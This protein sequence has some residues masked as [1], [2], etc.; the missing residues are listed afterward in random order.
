MLQKSALL[1]QIQKELQE[2]MIC[3]LKSAAKNLVFGKGNPNADIFFIGEAPGAKED[4]T[5]IPFV[6]S[7]GKN[8]DKLL[9]TIGL[10]LNDCYI[11]NIL[12]YRP[13]ENRNP[14]AD[15]IRRHTPYLVK[16]IQTIKP[17]ILVPLGNFATKFVLGEFDVGKMKKITGI[18]TLHGKPQMIIIQNQKFMVIPQFHPAAM[19]YNRKL[20][21]VIEEDFKQMGIFLKK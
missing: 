12:K 15:E 2:E 9:N 6:G 21:S 7:A 5:G 1:A 18:S 4:E 3:P 17:R 14:T 19:I 10:T 16:Q 8:L 11:A 20:Q 13:P